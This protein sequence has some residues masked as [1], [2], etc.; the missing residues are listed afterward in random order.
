ML[1]AVSPLVRRV[2]IAGGLVGSLL[3]AQVSF[4]DLPVTFHPPHAARAA[5]AT[6]DE[7]LSRSVDT[8]IADARITSVDEL[9]RFSLDVAGADLHFGLDHKTTLRFGMKER[10]GNCIEYA[11]LFATVFNRAASRKHVGARAYVV[12]SDARVLGKKLPLRGLDDH[13]W[14]LVVPSAPGAQRLFVD[15]TFYDFG[16]SWDISRSVSGDVRAP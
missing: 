16:L 12:H 9:L 8:R 14:V 7:E 5:A 11:H 13:D 10:E 15:P 1:A 4:A 3:F 2:L 6:L